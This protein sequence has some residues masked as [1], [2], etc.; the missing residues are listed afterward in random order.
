MSS[1]NDVPLHDAGRYYEQKFGDRVRNLAKSTA[2]S[3]SS[4]GGAGLWGGGGAVIFVIYLVIRL[5]LALGRESPRPAYQFQP[6]TKVRLKQEEVNDRLIPP[7]INHKPRP[8]QPPFWRPPDVPREDPQR[9]QG[10]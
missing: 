7:A 8:D 9:P 1:E 5:V 6:P 10:P 2:R 3:R 4:G